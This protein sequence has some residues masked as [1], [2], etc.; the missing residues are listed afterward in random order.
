MV[1]KNNK[2]PFQWILRFSFSLILA[3]FFIGFFLLWQRDLVLSKDT[4]KKESLN[5]KETIIVTYKKEKKAKDEKTINKELH[6]NLTKEIGSDGTVTSLLKSN[7][8]TQERIQRNAKKFPKRFKRVP[9]NAKIPDLSLVK[10]I[11]VRKEKVQSVM[12]RLKKNPRVE[13]VFLEEKHVPTAPND[14]LYESVRSWSDAFLNSWAL[15]QIELTPTGSG[16]SGWDVGT[17]SQTVIVAVYGTGID[18]THPDLENN[19]WINPEELPSSKFPGLDANIDNVITLNELKTWST[20]PLQDFNNDGKTNLKDL[21]TSHVNNY[22]LD[23][24]DDDNDEIADDF[25]GYGNLT[26]NDPY[27]DGSA[28]AGH[29][30]QMASIIGAV[31]NNGKGIAGINWNVR[32]MALQYGDYNYAIQYATD[33][34]ADVVNFSWTGG[35][36]Y[37]AEAINYAYANGTIVIFSSANNN[38]ELPYSDTNILS[39]HTWLVGS[40]DQ[41]DNKSSFSNY[42]ARLDFTAPGNSV[43]TALP[44]DIGGIGLFAS[45]RNQHLVQDNFAVPSLVYFDFNENELKYGT[46]NGSNWSFE[47]VDSGYLNGAYPTLDFDL[48]NN[49]HIAYYDWQNKRLKYATKNSGS[50]NLQTLTNSGDNGYYPSIKIDSNNYPHIA[51]TDSSNAIHHMSFD[52]ALWNDEIVTSSGSKTQIGLELD[53]ANNPYIVFLK[54][55]TSDLGFA[56]KSTGSWVIETPDTAGNV[57][58]NPSFVL[59][60][61]NNPHIAYANVTTYPSYDLKYAKKSGA[62]WSIETVDTGFIGLYQNTLML[63]TLGNPHIVTGNNTNLKYYSYNGAIWQSEDVGVSQSLLIGSALLNTSNEPFIAAQSRK[64]GIYLAKKTSSWTYSTIDGFNGNPYSFVSGT[65]PAAAVLSGVTALFISAHPTWT[66][67]QIYWALASSANDLGSAGHDA[68]FGWGRVKAKAAMDLTTP[69]S[70]TT[71]PTA[72]ITYPINGQTYPKQIFTITGTANDSYFTYYN[73]EY[74]LH[75]DMYWSNIQWYVRTGVNDSTLGSW[76]TSSLADGVYDLRLT[77]ADWYQTSTVE[78]QVTIGSAPSPTPT[79]TSTP[80]PTDTPTPT[81]TPTMTLTPTLTET[82]TPTPTPDPSITPTE[83]PTPTPT[84]TITPTS[85]PVPT[86]SPAASPTPTPTSIPLTPAPTSTPIPSEESSTCNVPDNLEAPAITGIT[87]TF[88]TATVSFTRTN[89]SYNE[90]IIHYGMANEDKRSV[91]FSN[92]ST[93]ETT[94]HTIEGLERGETYYFAVQGKNGCVV[95][96]EGEFSVAETLTLSSQSNNSLFNRSP[97]L[98]TTVIPTKSFMKEKVEGI[99]SGQPAQKEINKSQNENTSF[100]KKIYHFFL[101]LQ[102]YLQNIFSKISF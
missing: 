55:D 100:Q 32:L 22:F 72:I 73:L 38:S 2:E 18:Y 59:D 61:D 5:E 45:S 48:A 21:F 69:L 46:F 29:E 33:H 37:N 98:K 23:G 75:T 79:V 24:I 96:P 35:G 87:T 81:L 101:Y 14:P 8:T 41:N 68:Y 52:G 94:S 85:T 50:W 53:P 20:H 15:R 74:K 63:D 99:T 49:P 26:L 44:S 51:Y 4:S 102:T 25:V 6:E 65:S 58:Y 10:R 90:F 78:M 77:A 9:K 40:T 62:D 67:D 80:T 39:P 31:G 13:S 93:G 34:G 19:I 70:D 16:T 89:S 17:G 95:G 92:D 84:H 76:D 11:Q 7:T 47:V 82:P 3:V 91:S 30:T 66:I 86:S 60:A 71:A 42:G 36:Y 1:R 88:S 57:G 64:K 43:L 97:L 27:D 54:G 83:T 12:E 56:S 28:Y